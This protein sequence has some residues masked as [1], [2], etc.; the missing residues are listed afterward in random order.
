M[1][2]TASSEYF[3]TLFSSGMIETEQNEIIIEKEENEKLFTEFI[4][5]LYTGSLDYKNEQTMIEFMIIANKVFFFYKI[6][7][8]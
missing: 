2:L 8:L 3:E 4:K 6:S 7:I 1:I 5:F